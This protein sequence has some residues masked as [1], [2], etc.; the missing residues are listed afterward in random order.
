MVMGD[1]YKEYTC[2]TNFPIELDSVYFCDLECNQGSYLS[3]FKGI[4]LNIVFNDG[5]DTIRNFSLQYSDG[6]YENAGNPS[7]QQHY[8][9]F[10]FDFKGIPVVEKDDRFIVT[11]NKSEI[12]KYLTIF[13]WDTYYSGISINPPFDSN[14]SSTHYTNENEIMPD[15]VVTIEIRKSQ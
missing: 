9:D 10:F 4:S 2:D 11:L 15:A 14:K 8:R 13:N 6:T 12:E 7:Y 3:D 5:M 1:K